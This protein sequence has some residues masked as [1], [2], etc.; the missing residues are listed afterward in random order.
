[1]SKGQLAKQKR[2]ERQNEL[3]KNFTGDYYQEKRV[4]DEWYIKSWNGGTKR[5]QVS[6]YSEK[7]Y[8]GYK[9][10]NQ[11]RKEGKELDDKFEEQVH[12]ERPTLE[13]LKEKLGSTE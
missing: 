12:F 9:A 8:Q 7:S 1:M 10:F 11:A 3:L 6:V 5:W 2:L 13:S 4:G